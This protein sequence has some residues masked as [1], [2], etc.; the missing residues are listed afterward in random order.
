[1]MRRWAARLAVALAIA[2]AAGL[3]AAEPP[4]LTGKE[5]LAS[6]AADAQRVNDCKVPPGR[7]DPARPR[8]TE[9]GVPAKPAASEEAG[10]N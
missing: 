7:R 4:V 3:G 6:K 5:R 8:P 10:G 9:C 1:M 2:A